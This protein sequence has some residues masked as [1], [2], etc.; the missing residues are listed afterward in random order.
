[1]EEGTSTKAGEGYARCAIWVLHVQRRARSAPKTRQRHW[2][3]WRAVE[4]AA[5]ATLHVSRG[6]VMAPGAM[7]GASR[8]RSHQPTSHRCRLVPC[9]VHVC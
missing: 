8:V 6:R 3:Q 2:G 9:H 4:L 7:S 5:D 1:M